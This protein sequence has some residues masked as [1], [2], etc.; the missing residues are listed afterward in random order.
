MGFVAAPLSHLVPGLLLDGQQRHLRQKL[1]Y[2][3]PQT[4]N[5]LSL[6]LPI[7]A[8]ETTVRR[9]RRDGLG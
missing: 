5:K 2:G 4:V 7:S 9:S 6:S 3:A 1:V 8:C